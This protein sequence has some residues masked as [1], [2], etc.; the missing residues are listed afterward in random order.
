MVHP[1]QLITYS[2][3]CARLIHLIYLSA[4]TYGKNHSLYHLHDYASNMWHFAWHT[5]QIEDQFRNI[6]S[7]S[8]FIH[9]VSNE[10]QNLR[11]WPVPLLLLIPFRFVSTFQVST[12]WHQHIMRRS[13]SLWIFRVKDPEYDTE[14]LFMISVFFMLVGFLDFNFLETYA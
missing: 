7:M 6:C 1:L 11:Q 2:T 14:S 13:V 12:K 9:L 5:S 3:L 10:R 8:Q 4:N